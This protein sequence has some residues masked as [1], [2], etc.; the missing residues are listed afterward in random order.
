ME[1]LET[2][3]NQ[4]AVEIII[5]L[6]VSLIFAVSK[7]TVTF[8]RDLIVSTRY[9]G[10]KGTYY[11]YSFSTTGADWFVCNTIQIKFRLGKLIVRGVEAEFKFKGETSINERNIYI[12]LRGIHHVEEQ[13]YIF[14]TPLHKVIKR[15]W[16]IQSCISVIDEPVARICLLSNIPLEEDMLRLE[17]QRVAQKQK[18]TLLKIMKDNA[19]YKD[20]SQLVNTM[21]S[22][23]HLSN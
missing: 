14:F 11:I 23:S 16:G 9:S 18:H 13:H 20:N 4:Y 1:I 10:Y 8:F 7:S 6:L 2:A 19:V 3:I 12:N 15:L 21:T 5:G 22:Q 17:F